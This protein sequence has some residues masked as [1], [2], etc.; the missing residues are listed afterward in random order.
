VPM[1]KM[2]IESGSND[3]RAQT[4][5]KL[6]RSFS[7]NSDFGKMNAMTKTTTDKNVLL[8]TRSLN[9]IKAI[10]PISPA[11]RSNNNNNNS[12]LMSTPKKNSIGFSDD[13]DFDDEKAEMKQLLLQMGFPRTNV[14]KVIQQA[15]TIE[16]TNYHFI[17]FGVCLYIF[18][19][20]F[21]VCLS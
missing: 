8:P 9:V 4:D 18:S 16:G 19:W 11:K 6:W 20:L 17:S 2:K 14:L 13:D 7:M 10:N 3:S 12:N 21:V 5:S 1:K 15:W